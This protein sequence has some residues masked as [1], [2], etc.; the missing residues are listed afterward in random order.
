MLMLLLNESYFFSKQPHEMSMKRVGFRNCCSFGG[1][2]GKTVLSDH[3]N[4]CRL[5]GLFK[6]YGHINKLNVQRGPR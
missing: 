6:T 5:T 4:V 2:V 1:S 3:K